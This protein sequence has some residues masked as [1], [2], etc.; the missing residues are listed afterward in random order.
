MATPARLSSITTLTLEPTVTNSATP[1]SSE[2]ISLPI[3]LSSSSGFSC[4]SL[5]FSASTVSFKTSLNKSA[6]PKLSSASATSGCVFVFPV[7]SVC[8][9]SPVFSASAFSVPLFVVICCSV[10]VSAACTSIFPCFAV[11]AALSI[12]CA[13]CDVLTKFTAEPPKP[14]SLLLFSALTTS[15][16]S[17]AAST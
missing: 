13:F 7:L 5:S 14:V 2:L 11:I 9:S 3:P 16:L 1:V 8:V 12:T 10:L 4:F 15:E 6:N 17:S